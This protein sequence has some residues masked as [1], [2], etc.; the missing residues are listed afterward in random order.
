MDKSVIKKLK[1]KPKWKLKKERFELQEQQKTIRLETEKLES[2]VSQLKDDEI[3]ALKANDTSTIEFLD[4]RIAVLEKKIADNDKRYKA[5][6]EILEI[7]SK[8]VKNDKEGTS[9]SVGSAVGTITGLGGLALGIIGLR[10]AYQSDEVGSM[11]NKKTLDFV[12]R[13]PLLRNLGVWKK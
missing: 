5:N 6:A 13:L 3:A 12:N 7:Y 8:I 10:K 4:H 11:V 1:R 2:H 9:S